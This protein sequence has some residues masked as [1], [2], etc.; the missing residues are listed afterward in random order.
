[1]RRGTSRLLSSFA[2]AGLALFV[3]SCGP[4]GETLPQ[5]GATL[6]GT[7]H[8]GDEPIQFA[9]VIV[10]GPS[11][12]ASGKIDDDGRYHLDNVPLGEVNVAVNTKAGYGDFMTK[13]M[14]GASKKGG[15]APKFTQVP[16]KYHEPA[17]TTLKTTINKGPN[18]YDIKIPK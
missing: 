11:S 16:E 10:T 15:K 7:V 4:K 14:S 17:T 6:E 13:S 5:T 1:M 2:F 9:L 12:A 18:T 8:Y 3:C